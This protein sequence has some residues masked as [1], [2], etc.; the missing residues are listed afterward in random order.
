MQLI[1]W[2][3]LASRWQEYWDVHCVRKRKKTGT[4]SFKA[5]AAPQART[6]TSKR[7]R[8]K[9]FK[10]A[11]CLNGAVRDWFSWLTGLTLDWFSAKLIIQTNI[12][13]LN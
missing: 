13:V 8:W 3:G 7:S 10:A 6:L 9:Q 12:D 11:G 5:T 4:W 1:T 2:L